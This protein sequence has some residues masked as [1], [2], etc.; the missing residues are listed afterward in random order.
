MMNRKQ[1]IARFIKSYINNDY[2]FFCRSNPPFDTDFFCQTGKFDKASIDDLFWFYIQ[3]E[4]KI[5][6]SLD[7]TKDEWRQLP[8][9]HSLFDLFY[10]LRKYFPDGLK[11]NAYAHYLREGWK[12]DFW[13]GPYFNPEIYRRRSDWVNEDGN[14]LRHYAKFGSPQVISPSLFFDFD[15]YLDKA[16]KL[17]EYK[18]IIIRHY[19]L[20]DAENGRSPNPVFD[21]QAYLQTLTDASHASKDP[22]AHY[23]TAS[24][25]TG[26]RPNQWFDP[27]FYKSQISGVSGIE[28]ILSHYLDLGVHKGTYTDSRIASIDPK[29]LISILVP[30]Y[31]PEPSLL[32]CCIRS[33]LYQTYPN[34]ELCLA[35]DCSTSPEIAELLR[36]WA[37]KDDRIKIVFHNENKGISEATN[38]AAKLAGGEY[39]GFLDNDD[40]LAQDC[41]Y[42]LVK[43]INRSGAL[44]LYTDEDLIGDDSSRLSVFYKPDFNQHLLFSHNYV[45]HFLVAEKALFDEIGG[46]RPECDG[47]QDYDL[48]LRLSE[49]TE[50]ISHLPRILYHW[51]AVET[52]TSINHSRKSYAHEAGKHALQTTLKNRGLQARVEDTEFNFFY[53][54]RYSKNDE[55][56][57]SVIVA[58]PTVRDAGSPPELIS[59][60]CHYKNITFIHAGFLDI[61]VKD[62]DRLSR[63]ELLHR[64]AVSIESDYIV[65]IRHAPIA[66]SDYWLEELL[67]PLQQHDEIGLTCG[68][69]MRQ[70]GEEVSLLVPDLTSDLPVYLADFLSSCTRHLNGLHC[71]QLVSLCNGDFCMITQKLYLQLGGF[72]YEQFPELFAMHDLALKAC[73]SGY[74]ILYTPFARLTVDSIKGISEAEKEKRAHLEKK[75][76]QKRWASVLETIDPFYNPGILDVNNIDVAR[77]NEWKRGVN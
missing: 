23:L 67:T 44:V 4:R 21:P 72:D 61:D 16:S 15:Y 75:A 56:Q 5:R 28:P 8:N 1:K 77:F 65:F 26:Q 52:S 10:Y 48:I 17:K 7:F 38:S 14:P 66:F 42:Y 39:V 18:K 49:R 36:S 33:V 55:P 70:S 50:K 13:P 76:F 73:E 45:T 43:E 63:V 68:R 12:Q 27:D 57:I 37:G 59:D 9:P 30:V 3:F 34:W 62:E 41:L 31:N 46:F 24:L 54:P 29:P 69:I 60:N 40:E 19:R 35:D 58:P 6:A 25:E 53:H 51:R 22:F 2:R 64:E 47:A 32:N 74:K 20:Y 71:P 11:G